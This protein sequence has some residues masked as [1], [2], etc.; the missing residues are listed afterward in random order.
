M[1]DV[2]QPISVTSSRHASI[3]YIISRSEMLWCAEQVGVLH[4]MGTNLRTKIAWYHPR[5]L[6]L[7]DY[8][9]HTHHQ[10]NHAKYSENAEKIKLSILNLQ[11]S[12]VCILGAVC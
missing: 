2:L 9:V 10:S 6:I 8:N 1:L 3:E 11:L 12:G 7:P 5:L 4:R